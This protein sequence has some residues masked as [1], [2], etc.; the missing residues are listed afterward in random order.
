MV[1]ILSGWIIMWALEIIKLLQVKIKKDEQENFSF[2]L[3]ALFDHFNHYIEN[4]LEKNPVILL[5]VIQKLYAK[6]SARENDSIELKEFAQFIFGLMIIYNKVNNDEFILSNAAFLVFF[7]N[8]AIR[9]SLAL[10]AEIQRSIRE[11]KSGTRIFTSKNSEKS[12]SVNIQALIIVFNQIEAKVWNELDY[13]L[14]VDL[15]KLLELFRSTQNPE[16]LISFCTQMTHLHK[17]SDIFDAFAE[18]ALRLYNECTLTGKMP[19]QLPEE[20]SLPTLVAH[21]VRQMKTATSTRNRS[22][23]EELVIIPIS[24]AQDVSEPPPRKKA[25]QESIDNPP[26]RRDGFF[27]LI[28]NSSEQDQEKPAVE[29]LRRKLRDRLIDRIAE[30]NSKTSIQSSIQHSSTP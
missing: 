12:F 18:G 6:F 5:G 27:S 19:E 10:N 13:E 9:N 30:K 4:E 16:L 2:F 3:N 8:P 15:Q 7:K 21:R 25:R 17:K 1:Q 11:L 29:D 14:E 26:S 22:F 28:K 24:V 23:D 20:F